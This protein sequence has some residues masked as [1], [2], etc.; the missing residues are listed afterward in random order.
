MVHESYRFGEGLERA[1]LAFLEIE[2]RGWK[3]ERG[4]ALGSR[5]DTREFALRAFTGE[6]NTSI[7]R[8][9][10]LKLNDSAIAV[11]VMVFAGSTGFTVKTTYDEAYRSYS[12]GL[13]LEVDVISS[14]LSERWA[15]RLDAATAG[16]HVVDTLWPG[17]M[18]VADLVFS[19]AP[20]NRKL[21]FSALRHSELIRKKLR[22][23][24]KRV[25]AWLTRS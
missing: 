8:A 6:E 25:H 11:S 17:R 15:S 20:R 9:D 14:L 4:T 22:E 16:T 21:R 19:L 10:V 23:S 18:E 13:L 24:A 7:C 1:V 5:A 12:A 2:G 3:G